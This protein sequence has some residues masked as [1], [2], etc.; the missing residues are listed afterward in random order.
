MPDTPGNSKVD[1]RETTWDF[2]VTNFNPAFWQQWFWDCPYTSETH[3][4]G[5]K[6]QGLCPGPGAAPGGSTNESSGPSRD[7]DEFMPRQSWIRYHGTGLHAAYTAIAMN[8]LNRS[9]LQRG[10][11]APGDTKN[12]MNWN[13]DPDI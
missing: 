3:A 6:G 1:G 10:R 12:K 7:E 4:K 9:E 13:E 8:T 11:P 5:A 2:W